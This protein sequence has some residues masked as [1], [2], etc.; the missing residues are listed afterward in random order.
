MSAL[1]SPAGFRASIVI[2]GTVRGET[3]A[4]PFLENRWV[5]VAVVLDPAARL[6]TTYLDGAR[7]GQATNAAVN[8]AQIVNQ[9]VRDSNRLFIGRSQDD[10]APAIH[11]RLRDV[12]IYRVA[13]TDQQVATIRNNALAARPA[14]VT[15]RAGAGD[16][17]SRDPA[18]LAARLDDR[19]RPRHYRRD[20][21]RLAA[22]SPD[23]G[24]GQLS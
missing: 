13:L 19:E 1:A 22:P 15:A 7:V 3:T 20:R 24:R 17:D 14:T 12:R 2:D 16:F 8:G 5:H 9:T 11:A 4:A 10:A 18:G 23:R 6:L 21:R